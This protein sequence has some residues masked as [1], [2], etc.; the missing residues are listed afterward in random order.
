MEG[1]RKE[2]IRKM[3]REE[4]RNEEQRDRGVIKRKSLDTVKLFGTIWQ[5]KYMA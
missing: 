2:K 1:Q 3:E 4:K 5:N